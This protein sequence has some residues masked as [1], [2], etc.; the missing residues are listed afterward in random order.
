M[1]YDLK[2]QKSYEKLFHIL[3]SQFEDSHFICSF[4]VD[5]VA[6]DHHEKRDRTFSVENHSID[7]DKKYREFLSEAY[8]K[9]ID[10]PYDHI[11]IINRFNIEPTAE[12]YPFRKFC[13]E[14]Y[15]WF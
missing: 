14:I 12:R 4:N 13:R 3:V 11:F 8:Q 15:R 2:N 1:K 6:W 10:S 5:N 7:V 9:S